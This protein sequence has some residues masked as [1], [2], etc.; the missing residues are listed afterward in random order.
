MRPVSHTSENERNWEY[1]L[2]HNE[3]PRTSANPGFRLAEMWESV[4]TQNFFTHSDI[5]KKS[6]EMPLYTCSIFSNKKGNK[7][8][9]LTKL[10]QDPQNRSNNLLGCICL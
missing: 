5:G 6:S 2:Q 1:T 10:F 4:H 8:K 7:T 9:I 3:D